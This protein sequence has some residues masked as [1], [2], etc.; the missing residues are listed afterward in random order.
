[1]VVGIGAK[2]LLWVIADSVREYEDR[3]GGSDVCLSRFFLGTAACTSKRIQS[4][5]HQIPVM[6]RG[7]QR[8]LAREKALKKQQ[9]AC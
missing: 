7:N 1:M 6:T 4:Q 5:C 8:D 9:V 2:Q 3:R